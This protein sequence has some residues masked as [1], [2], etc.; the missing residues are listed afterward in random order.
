MVAFQGRA[1]T[2][3]FGAPTFGV[4]TA[5]GG[6]RLADGT[7]LQ[8]TGALFVDRNGKGDGKSLVPDEAVRELGAG[9]RTRQVAVE[10]LRQQR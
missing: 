8:L 1:N 9:D 2:R 5:N 4:S 6:Y 3:S 7:L 10:W